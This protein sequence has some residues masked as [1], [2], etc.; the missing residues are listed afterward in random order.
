MTKG[1]EDLFLFRCRGGGGQL[2]GR[3]DLLLCPICPIF[4]VYI[5]VFFVF[6]FFHPPFSFPW[7]RI[8]AKFNSYTTSFFPSPPPSFPFI[9]FLG[10][11]AF[12]T[13]SICPQVKQKAS[14]WGRRYPHPHPHIST[15]NTWHDCLSL[16]LAPSYQ[17]YIAW[18]HRYI[19]STYLPYII[20]CPG[21]GGIWGLYTLDTEGE[22]TIQ[23]NINIYICQAHIFYTG[24]TWRACNRTVFLCF[25]NP[26]Y[27]ESNL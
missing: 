11:G 22:C 13:I 21:G 24:N 8:G 17:L 6:V 14:V 3:I 20:Y 12:F 25:Q 1:S 10:G 4:G 18:K 9:S 15:M 2:W 27:V 16:P 26:D 23:G 7:F 5:P 19:P